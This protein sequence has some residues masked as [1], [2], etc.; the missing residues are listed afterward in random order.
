LWGSFV[1]LL[2]GFGGTRHALVRRD[3]RG[4][5]L[6][7]DRVVDLVDLDELDRAL[8]GIEPLDHPEL[9]AAREA[10]LEGRPGYDSEMIVCRVVDER[11]LFPVTPSCVESQRTRGFRGRMLDGD[12]LRLRVVRQRRLA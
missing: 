2:G 1:R 9:A 12:R 5:T 6:V 3:S 4:F 8:D 10:W 11:R 7:G